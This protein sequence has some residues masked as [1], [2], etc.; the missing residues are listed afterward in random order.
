MALAAFATGCGGSAKTP[1]YALLQQVRA[2]GD[3]VEFTFESAPQDVKAR[4]VPARSLAECGSGAPV[5]LRGTTFVAVH[6]SPAMTARIEG[7][8]VTPTYTGPKRLQAPGPVLEVA[9]T[10]DFEADVGWAVGL[11]HRLPYH[12]SREGSTV[13]VT[14]G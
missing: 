1:D 12:V 3:S 2:A 5:P 8:K 9:K 6:F 14:F 7:D 4:Y 11:S 13:T 10:C